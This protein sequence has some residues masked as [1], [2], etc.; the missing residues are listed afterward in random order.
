MLNAPWLET[1]ASRGILTRWVHFFSV[2]DPL[3]ALWQVIQA[4]KREFQHMLPAR[5]EWTMLEYDEI[6]PRAASEPP[7]RVKK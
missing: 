3:V 5:G 1:R 2:S 6:P 7:L 4:A